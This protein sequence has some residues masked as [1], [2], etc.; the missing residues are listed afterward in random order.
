M[1]LRP[2]HPGGVPS[3]GGWSAYDVQ[4]Q[5][6]PW[7]HGPL[8]R[9]RQ[10]DPAVSPT[11]PPSPW[12]QEIA[13]RLRKRQ[14][15]SFWGSLE[16]TLGG[17][18]HA[19][20]NTLSL[21]LP[22]AAKNIVD[23][24]GGLV[25]LDPITG[26]WTDLT[27]AGVS[28]REERPYM[29]DFLDRF[30]VP[31]P[32]HGSGWRIALDI[33]GGLALDPTMGLKSAAA[34]SA[35]IAAKV[36]RGA[37]T[38]T[39]AGAAS[40]KWIRAMRDQMALTNPGRVALAKG[41]DHE[42]PQ[43]LEAMRDSFVRQRDSL[44]QGGKTAPAKKMDDLVSRMDQVFKEGGSWR[45]D[46]GS[47]AAGWQKAAQELPD[48]LG[49][50]ERILHRDGLFRVAGDNAVEN[51]VR[52]RAQLPS[53]DYHRVFQVGEEAGSAAAQYR[54]GAGAQPL[55]AE[56]LRGVLP[57]FEASGELQA[58]GIYFGR[59]WPLTTVAK[60]TAMLPGLRG[61]RAGKAIASYPKMADKL[62]YKADLPHGLWS[63]VWPITAPGL[64]WRGVKSVNPG[65]ARKTEFALEN[66]WAKVAQKFLF[67]S[68]YKAFTRAEQVEEVASSL[69]L[70]EGRGVPVSDVHRAEARRMTTELESFMSDL[71]SKI[72]S[73]SLSV[74]R[75]REKAVREAFTGLSDEILNIMGAQKFAFMTDKLQITAKQAEAGVKSNSEYISELMNEGKKWLSSGGQEG[76][77]PRLIT[78]KIDDEISRYVV[79]GTIDTVRKKNLYPKG[80]DHAKVERQIALAEQFYRN[81]MKTIV[82]RS[83]MFKTI[84]YSHLIPQFA[85]THWDELVLNMYEDGF[86]FVDE[87]GQQIEDM[88]QV[89]RGLVTDVAAEAP[90]GSLKRGDLVVRGAK[91]RK[92][93]EVEAF[94]PKTQSVKLKGVVKPV[95]LVELKRPKPPKA[96][97]PSAR[98]LEVREQNQSIIR[99][100]LTGTER[101]LIEGS[102][103]YIETPTRMRPRMASRWDSYAK[104]W[105]DLHKNVYT[106][107][108]QPRQFSDPLLDLLLKRG[109]HSG[110]SP[111][112]HP[113]KDKLADSRRYETLEEMVSKGFPAVT[114]KHAIDIGKHVEGAALKTNLAELANIRGYAFERAFFSKKRLRSMSTRI[115]R[116]TD[117][118]AWRIYRILVRQA[119]IGRGWAKAEHRIHQAPLRIET[120][121]AKV[122]R[123]KAAAARAAEREKATAARVAE[124]EKAGVVKKEKARKVTKREVDTARGE[125]KKQLVAVLEGQNLGKGNANIDEA[126]SILLGEEVKWV[127]VRDINKIEKL[128][129]TV[130]K[131][132]EGVESKKPFKDP[133]LE[134]MK[135]TVGLGAK[136]K[137]V[138]KILRKNLIPGDAG[139]EAWAKKLKEIDKDVLRSDPELGR[140]WLGKAYELAETEARAEFEKI[141][142]ATL[143][144]PNLPRLGSMTSVMTKFMGEVD[145]PKIPGGRGKFTPVQEKALRKNLAKQAGIASEVI[146][147]A[148]DVTTRAELRSR[149]S[150]VE[151]DEVLAREKAAKEAPRRETM[152]ESV[153]RQN[154]AVDMEE[155]SLLRKESVEAQAQ[156]QKTR[157]GTGAY[158]RPR[159]GEELVLYTAEKPGDPMR[160]FTEDFA[161]A[162]KAGTKRGAVNQVFVKV[163]K[164]LDAT[165]PLTDDIRRRVLDKLIEDVPVGEVA[166]LKRIHEKILK[167][168]LEPVPLHHGLVTP[169]RWRKNVGIDYLAR[170]PKLRGE[171]TRFMRALEDV[172]LEDEYQMIAFGRYGSL[173]SSTRGGLPALTRSVNHADIAHLQP[174]YHLLGQ[175][176]FLGKSWPGHVD[177]PGVM[178]RRAKKPKTAANY[179]SSMRQ[180]IARAEKAGVWTPEEALV[181]NTMLDVLSDDV[182]IGI[183]LKAFTPDKS[184]K[185]Y[186]AYSEVHQRLFES[187]G[188]FAGFYDH[189]N[190]IVALVSSPSLDQFAKAA[191]HEFA[192][193]YWYGKMTVADRALVEQAW[194]KLPKSKRKASASSDEWFADLFSEWLWGNRIQRMERAD[195][196]F[197]KFR[198]SDFSPSDILEAEGK[199]QGMSRSEREV[200]QTAAP[201][202]HV[203]A[204]GREL[205]PWFHNFLFS[206]YSAQGK[207]DWSLLAGVPKPLRK[208]FDRIFQAIV[209]WFDEF[210]GKIRKR[211]VEVPKDIEDIFELKMTKPPTREKARELW[212]E[213]TVER[214]KNVLQDPKAVKDFPQGVDSLGFRR[215]V[216]TIGPAEWSDADI[217]RIIHRVKG[218]TWA[219]G[220]ELR[221]VR[222]ETEAAKV[223]SEAAAQGYVSRQV[224]LDTV[225]SL[226]TDAKRRK[227]GPVLV[228]EVLRGAKRSGVD[229]GTTKQ[230]LQSLRDEKIISMTADFSDEG[231][232][233]TLEPRFMSAIDDHWEDVASDD[234]YK[235][236]ADWIKEEAE[237]ARGTGN[238]YVALPLGQVHRPSDIEQ[239]GWAQVAGS[240][241]YMNEILA[242]IAPRK[243]RNVAAV[244]RWIK[245]SMTTGV[246]GVPFLAFSGRNLAGAVIQTLMDPSLG[247]GEATQG[248]FAI[249]HDM[250]L[251]RHMVKPVRRATERGRAG[252]AY[253]SRVDAINAFREHIARVRPNKGQA[254]AA[255][256]LKGIYIGNTPAISVAED[257]RKHVVGSDFA[258][259]EL[260]RRNLEQRPE[261]WWDVKQQMR[262]MPIS[263]KAKKLK[264]WLGM[265]LR[266]NFVPHQMATY[267]ED[268]VRINTYTSLRSKGFSHA[269]S[270]RRTQRAHIDYDMLSSQERLLR[271]FFPFAKFR[272]GT[273]PVVLREAVERPRTFMPLGK[274]EGRVKDEDEHYVPAWIGER[275]A[276]P[277][278]QD[279]NGNMNF[280]TSFGVI[281]EDVSQL[282]T[283][284]HLFKEGRIH[285]RSFERGVVS[286]LHP[287]LK[288]FVESALQRNSFFGTELGSYRRAPSW[289]TVPGLKQLFESTGVMTGRE[290]KDGEV[291]YEV[292]QWYHPI[293]GSIPGSRYGGVLS[294][295]LD[296]R[297]GWVSKVFSL[298]TGIKIATVDRERE[299]RKLIESWLRSQLASGNVGKLEIFFKRGSMPPED[300]ALMR[301]YQRLRKGGKAKPEA[302]EAHEPAEAGPY[303]SKAYR[304]PGKRRSPLRPQGAPASGQR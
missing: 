77:D 33:A 248:V 85:K 174:R 155:A 65:L 14:E 102:G 2:P 91:G 123:E 93:Y 265:N 21:R 176:N 302:D 99:G 227:T 237:A 213:Y 288:F 192:H 68:S 281:H 254:S 244:N 74:A 212:E 133:H 153:R 87:A 24:A 260:L 250:E 62:L 86:R 116:D 211:G 154:D 28:T 181:A 238:K 240:R 30:G 204:E 98:M 195:I 106:Q 277:L 188:S 31:T 45:S 216:E 29:S 15:Y 268:T 97:E 233:V 35:K 290:S 151:V 284:P 162:E 3:P 255:D 82:E 179:R 253:W 215:L 83:E 69:A 190:R 78:Q 59:H 285:A 245:E 161:R 224:V 275:V 186:A 55:T 299:K 122:A 163:G 105:M 79:D 127:N 11:P 287:L 274:I 235:R 147:S 7:L 280:L 276:I 119:E 60:Y 264:G 198:K 110:K 193:A 209:G 66:A 17:V 34:S 272:L 221:P 112:P 219:K 242:G 138:Q 16:R 218:E 72:R 159:K 187:D 246:L 177:L 152:S 297:K 41:I 50:L 23:V 111:A 84:P 168:L 279:K 25:T 53:M 56:T 37:A 269:D 303:P 141:L 289:M 249:L 120:K 256:R 270:L 291:R 44:L 101:Q 266:T 201:G 134:K 239:V 282:L 145:R 114:E 228:S 220:T 132:K 261:F 247:W 90:S 80:S 10:V 48:G 262:G 158:R 71:D 1:G 210:V 165:K 293:A 263:E 223:K 73:E 22:S 203:T 43:L 104:D 283:G 295:A 32:A 167:H 42:A 301:E 131:L 149:V 200:Y 67:G 143:R 273:T 4:S 81:Y 207:K 18:E 46:L 232:S 88:R 236:L 156:S 115:A 137:A 113:T 130:S 300:A 40:R 296:D 199:W 214:V 271:D 222:Y 38:A 5:Y 304:A 196:G 109:V 54:R 157:E 202:S 57:L 95:R 258:S 27:D 267:V 206:E 139:F 136:R 164:V 47:N 208:S 160:L 129:A 241:I 259:R 292:P 175:E 185:A 128:T 94:Y 39:R 96:R 12:S 243:Y 183:S 171:F 226:S 189:V 103:R 100:Y 36:S 146:D 20:W 9:Q 19:L 278:Y 217:N 205:G 178:S 184:K 144:D 6:S 194:M 75:R 182:V 298:S 257:M 294:K 64:A 172:A 58:G 166:G 8:A 140:V 148:P 13:Q 89:R 117:A 125:F 63:A 76:L 225:A 191:P 173:P 92:R 229:E 197:G 26:W 180:S 126:V 170:D 51:L 108:Y 70:K 234:V 135:R 142:E 252:Q 124:R 150:G 251:T 52:N 118:D 61:T 286:S 231:L 230:M 169:A 49:S 121:E 107:M